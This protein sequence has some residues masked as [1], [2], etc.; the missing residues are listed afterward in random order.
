MRRTRSGAVSCSTSSICI[1]C[2]RHV[3][4]S[5]PAGVLV[6]DEQVVHRPETGTRNRWHAACRQQPHDLIGNPGAA[7]LAG[8]EV[9]PG[10]MAD[11]RITIDIASPALEGEFTTDRTALARVTEEARCELWDRLFP[12]LTDG[13]PH[14][15]QLTLTA[16]EKYGTPILEEGRRVE[17][18]LRC[19]VEPV[20]EPAPDARAGSHQG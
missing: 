10:H 15:V 9:E 14:R 16:S 17:L 3:P 2:L 19:T 8:K 6:L 11:R 13:Q 12:L 18:R 20:H 1:Q 4:E 5:S 7:V